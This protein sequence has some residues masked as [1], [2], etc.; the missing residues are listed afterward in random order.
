MA[1]ILS[2]NADL[3]FGVLDIVL[4]DEGGEAAQHAQ[5]PGRQGTQVVEVVQ[6]IRKPADHCQ[7]DC[8]S[9]PSAKHAS[10]M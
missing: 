3:A 7:P 4:L 1:D 2:I 10:I 6:V 5:C 9:T 8:L